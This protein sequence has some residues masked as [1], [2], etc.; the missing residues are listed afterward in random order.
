MIFQLFPLLCGLA[1][2]CFSSLIREAGQVVYLL[3]G[4]VF[5]AAIIIWGPTN[6]WLAIIISQ[7]EVAIVIAAIAAVLLKRH[8][9][10]HFGLIAAGAIA[11]FWMQ[12]LNRLGAEPFLALLVVIVS[13]A[14]CVWAA[15]TRPEFVGNKMLDEALMGIFLLGL[16]IGLVPEII[17]GW[18]SADALQ[19]LDTVGQDG[20]FGVEALLVALGFGVSGLTWG[21]WRNRRMVN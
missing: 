14:I 17:G 16:M 9:W 2:V 10:R 6:A 4:F 15:L 3:L 13:L 18:Q 8:D 20:G 1:A 7:E 19:S 11:A 21:L 12:T 5:A